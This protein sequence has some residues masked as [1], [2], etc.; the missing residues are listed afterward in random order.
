ML[1]GSPKLKCWKGDLHPKLREELMVAEG[2]DL[3]KKL[4]LFSDCRS[5]Y[6]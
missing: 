6:L 2:D 1:E 5:L 4:P 3:I